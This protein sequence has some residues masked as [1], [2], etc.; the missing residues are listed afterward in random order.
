MRGFSGNRRGFRFSQRGLC[1]FERSSKRDT[2]GAL[3][4]RQ[5]ARDRLDLGGNLGNAL[6]LLACGVFETVAL[7]GEV[8]KRCREIRENLFSGGE[9][10]V[11][12]RDLGIDTVA[13]AGALS[14]FGPDCF[15]LGGEPGTCLFGIGGKPLLALRISRKLDQPQIELG[16]AVLGACFLAVKILKGDVEAMQRC[17]RASLG[18]SQFRHGRSGER[19]TF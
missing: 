9:F 19:L 5:F 7:R 10:A 17:A 3:Q 14:R 15:F 2:V 1:A 12:L 13:A 6:V 11:G 16:D 18:L 4:R 8:S